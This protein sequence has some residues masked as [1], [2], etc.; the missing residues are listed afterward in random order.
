[1]QD[2]IRFAPLIR[3]S[4]EKQAQKGESLHTQRKQLESAI[5]S[6]GGETY[7]WYAGQEHATQEHERKILEELIADAKEKKVDA[8][9]VT[10]ISRWSRD[11]QKSKEYLQILKMHE[12]KFFILTREVDLYDH[13]QSLMLG[14]SVE[15]AE[16]FAKEQK[17][18]SL[19]NRI[20]RA[21]KGIPTSG[22]EPFGREYDKKQGEWTITEQGKSIKEIA[23]LY[24]EKNISF[25]ELGKVFDMNPS[26]LCKILKYRCGDTWHQE[27][28][29]E[30][31]KIHEIIE[32]K[33]PRLLPE[34][35]IINI[36]NKCK[37][38][39][40]WDKKS[41]KH[42][43]LFSRI[44]FDE[45][46]GYALTGT[47][48][49]KGV[50]YYRTYRGIDNPYMVNADVIENSVIETL[51]EA[52]SNNNQLIKSVF[53][54]NP[55][56][57]VSD[58]LIKRRAV[59]E[60]ELKSTNNRISNITTAIKNYNGKDLKSFLKSFEREAEELEGRK[61]NLENQIKSINA[62]LE[63][64]PSEKEINDVRELFLQG[65]R[66]AHRISYFSCGLAFRDLPFENKRK[67]I[68]LLFAGQDQNGNRYGIFIK[69]LTGHPK[70][71]KVSAYGR[72]GNIDGILHS[73]L[74]KFWSFADP[75]FY[76]KKNH[77]INDSIANIVSAEKVKVHTPEK[78]H[79][80][81]GK[82]IYQRR[83]IGTASGL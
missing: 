75:S 9:M 82:C 76:S 62:Q 25:E 48:N 64:L 46:S 29:S 39:R 66:K 83:R 70:R 71:Y 65:I 5:H 27:F 21:K 17:F 35:I 36:R 58:E 11:N 53:D 34:E 77:E 8:I 61:F 40:T 1:M 33:V 60:K 24:L 18:K 56:S 4:T 47:P 54:G 6:L 72:L 28:K 10:D 15:I 50:R 67:I 81:Y 73:R 63:T 20:E 30:E 69:P 38:R 55:V 44:I 59:Y 19:L 74:G 37:N 26:N 43:Y 2:K 51:F 45:N 22:K 14:M 41:L 13:H 16:F 12:I 80:H 3:V 57:K 78:C 52:L 49:G 68:T 31:F 42:E 79:A 32:I 23:L 7:K